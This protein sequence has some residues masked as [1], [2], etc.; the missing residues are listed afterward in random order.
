LA[1]ILCHNRGRL[2]NKQAR[3]FQVRLNIAGE[4]AHAFSG[5]SV[6]MSADGNQ[7]AIGA[8]RMVMMGAAPAWNHPS[9]RSGRV[10]ISHHCPLM[11]EV[12]PS[13]ALIFGS[14]REEGY[15]KV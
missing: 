15:P 14:P 3:T 9:R 4:A 2:T 7:V 10:L 1:G 12:F 6:T 11:G 5:S 8:Y 13:K